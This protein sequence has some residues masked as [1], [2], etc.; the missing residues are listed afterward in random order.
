MRDITTQAK[1]TM[2]FTLNGGDEV[3]SLP[4]ASSIPMTKLLEIA[5]ASEKGDNEAA[6]CHVDFLRE[7]LGDEVV[8]SMTVGDMR[9]IVEAWQEESEAAGASEGE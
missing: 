3:Y 5:E 6:R 9:A 8:D 1:Q 7:H 4:L 2:E